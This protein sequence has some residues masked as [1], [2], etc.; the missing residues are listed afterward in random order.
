MKKFKIM[1]LLM[2]LMLPIVSVNAL[3]EE[4]E[5]SRETND[6]F[7]NNSDNSG[8]YNGCIYNANEELYTMSGDVTNAEGSLTFSV[9]STPLTRGYQG[10]DK[11]GNVIFAGCYK[12]TGGPSDNPAR[13]WSENDA[14]VFKIV[15]MKNGKCQVTNTDIVPAEGTTLTVDNGRGDH[16]RIQK[17]DGTKGVGSQMAMYSEWTAKNGGNCPLMFG[18]TANT[19]KWWIFGTSTKH[20]YVFT[21]N[22]TSGFQTD[23]YKFGTDEKYEQVQGCTVADTNGSEEAKACFEE[24]AKKIESYSCPSDLSKL[25]EMS[26]QLEAYQ[27]ECKSKL[28]VSYSDEYLK[29]E[30]EKNSQILKEKAREKINSCQYNKCNITQDQITK[31]NNAKSGKQCANGCLISY[32]AQSDLPEATC[33]CCGS[34]QGCT[35]TWTDNQR[36]NCGKVNKSK[37]QC[38]GDT[39]TDTC[40]SCLESAYNAA[41]LTDAQKKCMKD[42]DIQASETAAKINDDINNQFNDQIKKDLEEN[43]KVREGT[44]KAMIGSN[45]VSNRGFGKNGESCKEVVGESLSKL[46]KLSI[47]VL[48]IA[49]ALIAIIK[50]M[51]LLIPPIMSGEADKLKQAGKQCTKLAIILLLIGVFPTIINFLGNIFK[52]DLTCI[53]D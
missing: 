42:S 30:A 43:A 11:D 40:L 18:V 47:N 49:G 2:L 44:E 29:S 34:S 38:V 28:K 32:K 17:F 4:I 10:I 22:N 19:W 39:K 52:Y 20:K 45:T 50:G 21:D 26:S 9:K 25:S 6:D 33:Y 51:T 16:D 5:N 35:Y 8:K 36:S 13:L 48:R 15:Q 31:I 41:G 1:F 46:I 3:E 24:A 27:E 53:F 14:F 12:V 23:E 37:A 7:C